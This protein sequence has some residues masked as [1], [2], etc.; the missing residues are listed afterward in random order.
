MDSS[1]F[2]W[3]LGNV[4]VALQPR[5]L[6]RPPY[7]HYWA[8]DCGKWRLRKISDEKITKSCC[9]GRSRPD[10]AACLRCDGLVEHIVFEGETVETICEHYA[11]SIHSLLQCNEGL[12]L[13]LTSLPKSL[14]VPVRA[15][16]PVSKIQS[17]ER[18]VLLRRFALDTDLSAE[19]AAELLASHGFDYVRAMT[20]WDPSHLWAE[21]YLS[22]L[23]QTAP[24]YVT[25]YSRLHPSEGA[26]DLD[27]AASALPPPPLGYDWKPLPNGEW[28]LVLVSE[29]SSLEEEE[30]QE[31]EI[32]S[33][34]TGAFF[35]HRIRPSDTLEGV[36]LKN[37]VTQRAVMKLNHLS[38]NRI[39][40][41][42][43]LRIPL[44]PDQASPAAEEA[45]PQEAG[46]GEGD[47]I[48]SF[49][50]ETSLPLSGAKYY[51][52]LSSYDY[53]EALREWRADEEWCRA[54]DASKGALREAL[55]VGSY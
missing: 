32:A 40:F 2:A 39:Q 18:E 35:V 19:E 24:I 6:S 51:L 12:G 33:P 17:V 42:T 37:R 15:G 14:R 26:A 11:C 10:E 13:R 45:V 43:E 7:L 52:Q 22:S 50:Q 41:L 4:E 3:A 16:F 29:E 23:T 34:R 48:Q 44:R 38:S 30:E 5:S 27:T 55:E 20:Q 1:G 54:N 46:A 21:R 25:S 31:R 8:L 47:L 36:C 9:G 28:E 49:A 53:Q